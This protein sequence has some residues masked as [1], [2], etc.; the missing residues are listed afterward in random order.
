MDG[1]KRLIYKIQRT[2]DR[3][4]AD[5]LIRQYYD[6]IYRYIYKQTSD[7]HTAMDLT[8]NIFVSML[9]S[10][11]VYDRRKSTFR[12]WLYRIATNKTIDYFRSRRIESTHICH[13]EGMEIP[14]EDMFFSQIETKFLLSQVQEYVNLLDVTQQ[15]IF[16]LKFFGEY[17]FE[18]IAVCMSLP[19][20]TVK[21]KYYRLLKSLKEE[22]KDD[23]N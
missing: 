8:Q 5:T 13:I 10:I 20:S 16:R 14:Y 18:Q 3:V 15:H 7:E 9:K 19:E 23:Y 22:F 12:T 17:T 21:S 4:A 2:G 6:E 1:E 11:S